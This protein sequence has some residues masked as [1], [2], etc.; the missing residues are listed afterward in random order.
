ME[1]KDKIKLVQAIKGKISQ[2]QER[3]TL[4][5][6]TKELEELERELESG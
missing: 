1:N 4:S 5:L 3:K 6:E 2:N